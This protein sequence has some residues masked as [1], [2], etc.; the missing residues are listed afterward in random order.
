MEA[1]KRLIFNNS[2]TIEMQGSRLRQFFEN[3]QV[4]IWRGRICASAWSVLLQSVCSIQRTA[5]PR[6][7]V[8]G[9]RFHWSHEERCF[10]YEHFGGRA[11]FILAASA[12]HG[13][14]DANIEEMMA[15]GGFG[16]QA[17]AK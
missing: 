14:N 17:K 15:D 3:V 5:E 2:F 8:A 9:A 12:S 1:V 10:Q 13:R 16:F 7:I 4:K 6:H 11:W